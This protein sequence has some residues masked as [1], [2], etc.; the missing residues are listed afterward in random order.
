MFVLDGIADRVGYT[1]CRILELI[2]PSEGFVPI[3]CRV[4]AVSSFHL[5]EV[6]AI[7]QETEE[8]SVDKTPSWYLILVA[9]GIKSL[10]VNS[11]FSHL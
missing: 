5:S 7:G 3:F 9:G 8:A 4:D 11:A 1:R 2:T 6:Q 10:V